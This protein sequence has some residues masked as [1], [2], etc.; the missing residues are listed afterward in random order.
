MLAAR[1]TVY[2]PNEVGRAGGLVNE[3]S[4]INKPN[5]LRHLLRVVVAEQL[6]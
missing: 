3:E 6:V 2:L 5:T 4:A 1:V